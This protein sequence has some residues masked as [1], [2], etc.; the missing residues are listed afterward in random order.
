LAHGTPC[1]KNQKCAAA[2]APRRS[3]A[4]TSGFE[5]PPLRGGY[6][7]QMKS[8]F[9]KHTANQLKNM[10]AIGTYPNT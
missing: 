2:G 10:V 7:R 3:Y 4:K 6:S 1:A 5:P 9:G 8:Y